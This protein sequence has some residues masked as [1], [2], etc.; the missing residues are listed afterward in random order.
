MIALETRNL[1]KSY[2]IYQSPADRL[3]EIIS[4]RPHHTVFEALDG[5]SFTVL[6][7]ETL[8]IIGENGAGKSTLLKVLAR[9]LKPTSGSLTVNG[10]TAALLELGAGF[11]PELTGEENIY[12]NAYLMGLSK[13]EIDAKKE[14]I[15]D[16]SEL[17]D[18]MRRPVKTYSSGM[19]MRL[20]FSIATCVDPDILIVDEALSVGDQSFQKKCIDR[21]MEFK[22]QGKTILFCSHAMYL[23]QELCSKSLWLHHGKIAEIGKT[24]KVINAYNDWMREK[25]AGM[26]SAKREIPGQE[27]KQPEQKTVWLESVDLTDGD[28]REVDVIK[29]GQEICLRMVIGVA[30]GHSPNRGY[31]GF[32]L[33]RNDEEP[34]FGATTKIDGYEAVTF[35]NGQEVCLRFPS[36]SLLSGHYYFLGVL[37]DDHALHL[38]DIKRT[39]MLH[40]ENFK[41][42]FGIV[43]IGHSWE[44][45]RLD[46]ADSDRK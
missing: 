46:L 24:A 32:G 26:T 34:I 23:V 30:D 29:T 38:Y 4:R 6:Q 31:V 11:N 40:V 15:V 1:T 21:M 28:G 45:P 8:G 41:G 36:F 19:Y 37:M 27:L 7:G 9:T 10:R 20:A 25:D 14:E 12:L 39:K 3:K 44:F 35:R 33:N 5:I 13:A 22:K 17:S 16:F 43:T 2:R 42:E 18:F